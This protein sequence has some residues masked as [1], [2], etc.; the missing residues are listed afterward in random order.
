MMEVKVEFHLK[1]LVQVYAKSFIRQRKRSS[2]FREP[3]SATRRMARY[4]FAYFELVKTRRD[5]E[6]IIE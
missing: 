1:L 2:S 6:G 5:R 4:M 3:G